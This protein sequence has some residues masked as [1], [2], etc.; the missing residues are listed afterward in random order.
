[1]VFL[2][3]L[4]YSYIVL[5]LVLNLKIVDPNGHENLLSIRP[6]Q[7]NART[8][9]P[10]LVNDEAIWPKPFKKFEA[11]FCGQAVKSNVFFERKFPCSKKL[12][13]EEGLKIVSIPDDLSGTTS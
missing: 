1:M 9:F 2:S 13:F 6:S 12:L 7:F 10:E 3:I 4:L 11:F 8:T 5:N